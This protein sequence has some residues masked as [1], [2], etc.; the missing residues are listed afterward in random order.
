M[1]IYSELLCAIV[2][3]AYLVQFLLYSH[4]RNN[5]LGTDIFDIVGLPI[6]SELNFES[7]AEAQLAK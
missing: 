4:S 7:D 2:V 5:T 3:I 1:L 6:E